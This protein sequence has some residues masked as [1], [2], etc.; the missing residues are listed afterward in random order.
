MIEPQNTAIA[1]GF[2]A[3]SHFG[4]SENL[5]YSVS[6]LSEGDTSLTNRKGVPVQFCCDQPL[7]KRLMS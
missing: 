4:Q 5:A 6:L 7:A 2:Q 3:K 1:Y